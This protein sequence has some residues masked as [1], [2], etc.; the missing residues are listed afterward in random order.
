MTVTDSTIQTIAVRKKKELQSVNLQLS[1]NNLG[2]LTTGGSIFD[3]NGGSIFNANR[4][5]SLHWLK[6]LLRDIHQTLFKK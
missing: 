2:T 6:S 4:Q 3:A 5:A 1:R